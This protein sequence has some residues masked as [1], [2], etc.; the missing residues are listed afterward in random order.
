MSDE[1]I[2]F[3]TQSLCPVC[4]AKTDADIVL[5]DGNYFLKKSCQQ[6]GTFETLVWKDSVP[7]ESWKL[8]RKKAH[9]IN[10]KTT[11]HRGCPYDC[12]LCPE[13]RQHTCT[14]LIEVTQRCN[15]N[16]RFCFADSKCGDCADPTVEEISG[17]YENILKCS[18]ACNIQLSGGEPT[19]RDDLPEIIRNGK[20]YGFGFIQLNTNGIRLAGDEAYAKK[21][22]DA[23]LDSVF[24]QF[25]GTEDRIFRELR[26]RELLKLKIKAIENCGKAGVGVVLVPTLV[27]GVNVDNVGKIIDFALAHIKTVRGVHFQPVSYFG[28][29]PHQPKDS[30]R[31]LLP[32]LMEEIE[33]QTGGRIKLDSLKAPQCENSFCSF[34]G[35]FIYQG[36]GRLLPLAKSA[37]G[38]VE[39]AEEGAEKTKVYVS[40]NWA[41]RG[42]R[43][44]ADKQDSWDK[45]LENIRNDSFSLSAMAFQDV[46]NIDLDRVMDCCIHVASPDGRLIPFCLYNLTDA[47]GKALYREPVLK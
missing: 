28:R 14:A 46:W 8:T 47:Q 31:I 3:Q 15:L 22:K 25:D 1:R 11:I 7:M 33:K 10:P 23:G 27:P 6:H 26:G 32:Q 40:G 9:I 45:I 24:L 35:R 13:H 34:H 29:V 44:P 37:C 21:L 39:K 36:G 2:I 19:M 42:I 38:C 5:R 43:R 12:G 17:I 4:M 20:K 16:C 18:G 30:D 41:S